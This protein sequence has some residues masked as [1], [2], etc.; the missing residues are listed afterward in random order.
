MIVKLTEKPTLSLEKQV[1]KQVAT[2]AY[3]MGMVHEYRD[4]IKLLKKEIKSTNKSYEEMKNRYLLTA[5]KLEKAVDE[6][7]SQKEFS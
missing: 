4:E 1:E 6:L 3:L 7:V 5:A 2:N